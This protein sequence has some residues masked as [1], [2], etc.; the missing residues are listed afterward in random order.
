MPRNAWPGRRVHGAVQ[1][2]VLVARTRGERAESL[3]RTTAH[4]GLEPEPNRLGVRRQRPTPT[5]PRATDARRCAR[6]FFI[7]TIMPYKYGSPMFFVA[8][9]GLTSRAHELAGG[10]HSTAALHHLPRGK[11]EE[12]VRRN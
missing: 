1:S 5:S 10:G 12:T 7:Q 11:V 4:Q 6:V 3:V 2:R 8:T 9:R